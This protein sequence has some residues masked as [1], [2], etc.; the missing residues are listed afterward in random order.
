MVLAKTSI[1]EVFPTSFVD[2]IVLVLT[3]VMQFFQYPCLFFPI[4]N[5]LLYPSPPMPYKFLGNQK[6]VLFDKVVC[7]T[8]RHTCDFYTFS[9][10]VLFKSMNIFLYFIDFLVQIFIIAQK[11][12]ESFFCDQNFTLKN[13]IFLF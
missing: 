9:M 8:T 4:Y 12:Q 1:N 10:R 5:K 2:I 6:D 7:N 13:F 11:G 3:V